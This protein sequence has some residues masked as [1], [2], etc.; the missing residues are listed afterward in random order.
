M[1]LE[2][3][4]DSFAL[5]VATNGSRVVHHPFHSH[6]GQSRLAWTATDDLHNHYVGAPASGGGS[7]ESW[8]GTYE[9]EPP[10]DP[11]AKVLNVSVTGAKHRCVMRIPL[12][13]EPH[14]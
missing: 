1:S 5:E 9:F 10:I 11:A 3:T 7:N 8:A 6:V 4:E 14:P 2:S 12:V 13:W